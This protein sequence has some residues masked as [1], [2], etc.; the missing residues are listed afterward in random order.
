LLWLTSRIALA[1]LRLFERHPLGVL[2][3]Q[4][5]HEVWTAG[6]PVSV[7]DI[8]AALPKRLAYTTVMTTA[9]RL[10]TKGFLERVRSGKAFLY[11]ARIT[12]AELRRIPT[13][14]TLREWLR[15]DPR[16]AL[17]FLIETVSTTDS[18]LLDELDRLIKEKKRS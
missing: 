13:A 17:S 16:P 4:V 10:A 8:Q 12:Q 3:R 6:R 9:A 7:R 2:E 11:S 1:V 15:H 18:R 5:M 14:R